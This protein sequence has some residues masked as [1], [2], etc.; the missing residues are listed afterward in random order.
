MCLARWHRPSIFTCANYADYSF[1]CL[2]TTCTCRAMVRLAQQRNSAGGRSAAG[3]RVSQMFPAH[4]P[5]FFS[6]F[7]PFLFLPLPFYFLPLS[8]PLPSKLHTAISTLLSPVCRKRPLRFQLG[9]LGE[10][11]KLPQ[12]GLSGSPAANKGKGKCI[13]IAPLL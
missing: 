9:S 1:V 11:C 3:P 4:S 8:S 5:S 7:F 10:R 12:R 13:Y 6:L 2:L